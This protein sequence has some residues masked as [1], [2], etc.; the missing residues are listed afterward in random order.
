M[1]EIKNIIFDLGG[2]LLNID[3]NKTKRAFEKL[4]VTNFDSFYSKESANPVFE[5]LETGHISNESFY[6]A[7]QPYCNP[8]TTF[9]QIQCAWNEI[10]LDFRYKS[11]AHLLQLKE[12]YNLFLL[13]NTNAIHHAEFSE[14]FKKENEGFDFDNYFIKTYYSHQI[15]KRKP[16]PET[17]LYVVNNAGIKA[18]E[19]LFIDD[20]Q[21]NIEGARLAGLKTKLLLASEKIETLGL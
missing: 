16:Y 4:G 10:L 20:S 11:V 19:T 8:G 14:S 2:V 18:G 13:S 9:R 15:Q 6:A 12:K 7:V 1:A 5:S 17:Y 21:S 3:F